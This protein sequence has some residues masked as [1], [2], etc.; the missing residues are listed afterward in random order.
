MAASAHSF[1]FKRGLVMSAPHSD[2]CQIPTERAKKE[3]KKKVGQ[4]NS[5]QFHVHV[6][7][8]LQLS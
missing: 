7:K 4:L 6:K 1:H 3:K 2:I 5:I 8:T